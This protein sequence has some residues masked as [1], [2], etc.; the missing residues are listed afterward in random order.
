MVWG[1]MGVGVAA[2]LTSFL[3]DLAGWRAAFWLPGVLSV[4]LGV[5]YYLGFS[6]GGRGQENP[7]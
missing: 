1:N 3:I 7:R 2:L 4:V 6:R 5:V